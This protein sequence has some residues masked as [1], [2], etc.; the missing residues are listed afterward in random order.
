[1]LALSDAL[2]KESKDLN[3]IVEPGRSL[4]CLV[5]NLFDESEVNLFVAQV[6]EAG[7][8]VSKVLGTKRV[9]GKNLMIVDAGMSELIRPCLYGS[10]HRIYPIKLNE[11]VE[12]RILFLKGVYPVYTLRMNYSSFRNTTWLD[13]SVNLLISWARIYLFRMC[14]ITLQLWIVEHMRLLCLQLII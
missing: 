14:Q 12:V 13:Q 7:I 2:S 8:L 10:H 4:V 1:M 9:G 3:I 11:D 6:A 5:R